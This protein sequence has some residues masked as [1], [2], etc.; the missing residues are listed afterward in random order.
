LKEVDNKIKADVHKELKA[1]D[2]KLSKKI[3][4]EK[5]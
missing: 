5:A 3:G 4:A 1:D 2:T